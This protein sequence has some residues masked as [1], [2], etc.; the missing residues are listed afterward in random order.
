VYGSQQ[1]SPAVI[2]NFRFPGADPRSGGQGYSPAAV[3]EF[4]EQVA[5]AMEVLG[6]SDSAS[7]IRRE[8]ERSSEI[9]AR[10]VLAGHE[11]AER[12]RQQAASDAQAIIED[13]KRL[14]EALRDAAR[15]ETE[16]ARE[17]VE[18][19]RGSFIEELRD[20]YDRI[21]ATLYR[22]ETASRG[23]SNDATP[24]RPPAAAA[25]NERDH[26]HQRYTGGEQSADDLS[27]QLSRDEYT[28]ES[29]TPI[30]DELAWSTPEQTS[31]VTDADTD[32]DLGSSWLDDNTTTFDTA[33]AEAAP[34]EQLAPAWTQIPDELHQTHSVSDLAIAQP[35]WA[36]PEDE[37]DEADDAPLAPGEPLVDLRSMH[38]AVGWH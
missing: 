23:G 6:S 31:P 24:E 2:R 13:A 10:M 7:A 21:G 17:H 15:N 37:E 14:T 5:S 11:T 12:L 33:P 4:L 32:D 29:A 38:G 20:M 34:A 25:D 28:G 3:H 35:A 18:Q 8:L 9:S 26:M 16:H 22:F 19:L 30:A 27:E 1:L 36:S